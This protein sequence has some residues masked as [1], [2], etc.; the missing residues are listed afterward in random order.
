M[1]GAAAIAGAFPVSE[2][3]LPDYDVPSKSSAEAYEA[4]Q[5][6]IKEKG[7]RAERVTRDVCLDV[8]GAELCIFASD[9]SY[10]LN[11]AGKGNHNDCSLVASLKNGADSY[12]FAADMQEPGIRAFLKKRSPGH[13]VLKVPHHAN[14]IPGTADLIAAVHP[15]LAVI[16]DGPQDPASEEVLSAVKEAGAD[17][18]RTSLHGNITVESCGMGSYSVSAFLSE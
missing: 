14:R 7:I 2:I 3:F 8:S 10:A 6:V 13:D 4:L 5:A 18:Y 15:R 9:I 17:M 12:L 11:E 16:T 1:G